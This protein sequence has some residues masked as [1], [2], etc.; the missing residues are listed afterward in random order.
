MARPDG[1]PD[2]VILLPG[3][4]VARRLSRD[5]RE[6]TD[7][8]PETRADG[9]SAILDAGTRLTLAGLGLR[10]D[11]IEGVAKMTPDERAR[12]MDLVEDTL[13]RDAENAQT[14]QQ[15][16][17]EIQRLAEAA[18]LRQEADTSAPDAREQTPAIVRA[19]A[20][21]FGDLSGAT[22]AW[23]AYVQQHYTET[24]TTASGVTLYTTRERAE[25]YRQV[26]A[27]FQDAPL[28]DRRRLA[29]RVIQPAEDFF[30]RA[31]QAEAE[32]RPLTADDRL[33]GARTVAELSTEWLR[34]I[35]EGRL[36][37]PQVRQFT[38]LYRLATQILS[39][40]PSNTPEAQA[41]RQAIITALEALSRDVASGSIRTEQDITSRFREII[42]GIDGQPGA[43]AD[44]ERALVN[45]LQL[46]MAPPTEGP[47]QARAAARDADERRI[48]ELTVPA[49]EGNPEA[50]AAL[51]AISRDLATRIVQDRG[52]VPDARAI[53][54]RMARD[55][56][57]RQAVWQSYQLAEQLRLL[58]LARAAMGLPPL[59]NAGA[60]T[61]PPAP[62]QAAPVPGDP[63]QAGQAP[64]G[65]PPSGQAV[66]EPT[67]PATQPATPPESDPQ[68]GPG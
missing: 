13:R 59:P 37:G 17:A 29:E 35:E 50:I 67:R 11:Q 26:D 9:P 7:P 61:V 23:I 1:S 47:W 44:I 66:S 36:T 68:T 55:E 32:Q 65:S 24:F 41:R 48:T 18:R 34:R 54:E 49:G 52:Q 60:V 31:D 15:S 10:P 19:L 8:R 20:G 4:P 42:N 53:A 46:L 16:V 56:D 27:A 21:R 58:N 63:P 2:N 6:I 22:A 5:Y 43:T 30:K 25:L 45:E 51:T 38:V 28:A 62:P 57:V 64:V 39:R 33:L 14:R 3:V 40:L 12:F